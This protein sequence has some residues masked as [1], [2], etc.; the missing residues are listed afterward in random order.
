MTVSRKEG[1]DSEKP[2]HTHD[3]IQVEDS[4]FVASK[5]TCDS[6]GIS[7]NPTP[8]DDFGREDEEYISGYRLFAALFGITSAFFIVLLDFSIISTKASKQ[9]SSN[10]GI[11]AALQPLT[12]KLYTY[13]S[14]KR[15]FLLFVAIFEIGSLLCAV[16]TSSTFFILGRTVAGLGTSGLENGALTLIAG[17]VPLHKRPHFPV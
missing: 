10:T 13:L 17:A 3:G 11:S 6:P 14:A 9:D 4:K 16:S 2:V 7:A 1:Q 12:G 8:G 15:T 5:S